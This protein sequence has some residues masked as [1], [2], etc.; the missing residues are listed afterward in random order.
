VFNSGDPEA[1]ASGKITVT[2]YSHHNDSK[3]LIFYCTYFNIIY[4]GPQLQNANITS[5]PNAQ[6]ISHIYPAHL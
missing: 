5:G 2:P 1:G 4:F 6:N 3:Y